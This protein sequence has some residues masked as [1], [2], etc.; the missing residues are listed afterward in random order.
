MEK[1]FVLKIVVEAFDL[2]K[3]YAKQKKELVKLQKQFGIAEKDGLLTEEQIEKVKSVISK[4][5][6]KLLKYRN[7][8]DEIFSHII[9]EWKIGNQPLSRFVDDEKLQDFFLNELYEK[10]GKKFYFKNLMLKD[11]YTVEDSDYY[12]TYTNF[13][14]YKVPLFIEEGLELRDKQLTRQD[15]KN[16]HKEQKIYFYGRF[17]SPDRMDTLFV[18]LFNSLLVKDFPNFPKYLLKAINRRAISICK[19]EIY[20]YQVN[21]SERE[22][23]INVYQQDIKEMKK[24]IEWYKKILHEFVDVNSDELTE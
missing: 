21:I 23:L 6:N 18:D 2:L 20:D 7:K 1:D 8:I 5:E 16:L 14:H 22:E 24:S 10:Y 12:A 9:N 4:K 11:G 19:N 3:K 17:R 13:V 15:L